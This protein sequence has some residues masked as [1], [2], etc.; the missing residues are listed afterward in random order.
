MKKVFLALGLGVLLGEIVFL[1]LFP[2]GEDFWAHYLTAQ[3]LVGRTSQRELLDLWPYPHGY[4]QLPFEALLVLPLSFLSPFPAL[5]LWTGVSYLAIAGATYLWIKNLDREQPLGL[6]GITL[7]FLIWPVTLVHMFRGQI[8]SLFLLTLVASYLLAIRKREWLSGL[9]LSLGLIKP[10]LLAGV[11]AGV[12]LKGKWRVLL[13]FLIGCLLLFTVSLLVTPPDIETNFQDYL[14][15]WFL[16][17]PLSISLVGRFHFSPWPVQA[18]ASALGLLILA[19]W[20]WRKHSP[21]LYDAAFGFLASLLL[22][23]HLRVYDLVTLTP[24]FALLLP[25]RNPLLWTSLLLLS[26]GGLGSLRFAL[27]D[28]V[29]L[30][31]I[32]LAIS[33]WRNR[34]PQANNPKGVNKGWQRA[35]SGV[36]Y[37]IGKIDD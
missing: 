7:L 1:S 2:A 33:L 8:T 21:T 28:L 4:D 25:H 26:I 29:T 31:L 35:Q 27:L 20:W 16:G 10:H 13:G 36:S 37:E 15:Q 11:V 12:V 17:N 19:I 32:V 5:L 30:S 22:I 34:A 23:P 9:V 24:I 18:T 6:A 14:T 3:L